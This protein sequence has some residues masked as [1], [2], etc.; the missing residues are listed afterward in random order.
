[1]S[2]NDANSEFWSELCGTSLA[3]SLGIDDNSAASLQKFDN[4]YFDF[5]DYL[6]PFVDVAAFKNRRVLEV[7]LGY[8]SLSQKIAEAG[9]TFT[10]LDIASD[11]VA[12][13]NRRLDQ[14][15]LS[16]RAVQG[17]VLSCPFEDQS[18]DVAI[19]IGSLHHTG[20]LAGALKELRRILVPGGQ[21][22]FMVY[23]A[24]SYRRIIRWPLTSIRHAL[25]LRGRSAGKPV[26]GEAERWAYDANVDGVAAPETEFF[27]VQEL[28]RMLTDWSIETVRLENIGDEGPLRFLTRSLKLRLFG[29]WLGLD[30]YIRATR[31]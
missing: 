1:M 9:A 26:A 20:S 23:N 15:R 24:F 10:G 28:R 4:W 19:A 27:S 7:G 12:M 6:L 18:F 16:G 31:R 21:L 17:S 25:W 8:G 29:P 22:I 14:A 11:P 30:I 3:R 5:Y 2:I 13:V